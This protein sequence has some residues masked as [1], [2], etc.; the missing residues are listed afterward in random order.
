MTYWLLKSFKVWRAGFKS[1]NG[2]HMAQRG[3]NQHQVAALVTSQRVA[4]CSKR[5]LKSE[6][7][8][9]SNDKL[10]S[11]VERLWCKKKKRKKRQTNLT[12]PTR[13]WSEF[14][15]CELFV[16]LSAGP[17]DFPRS[18]RRDEEG[19]GKQRQTGKQSLDSV[20]SSPGACWGSASVVQVIDWVLERSSKTWRQSSLDL[21]EE[22]NGVAAFSKKGLFC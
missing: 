12:T 21:P 15:H 1:F 6:R 14:C 2:L 4:T 8:E 22:V 20:F 19:G 13:S 10:S 16:F 18:L 5:Y 3:Q 9:K 7:G 17:E 11:L